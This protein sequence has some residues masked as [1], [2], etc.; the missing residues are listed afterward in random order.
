VIKPEDLTDEIKNEFWDNLS[1]DICDL[2]DWEEQETIAA[3]VNAWLKHELPKRVATAAEEIFEEIDPFGR[4][5]Q[6]MAA[7]AKVITRAITGGMR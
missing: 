2:C 1:L 7:M 5:D 4:D 3:A 6:E